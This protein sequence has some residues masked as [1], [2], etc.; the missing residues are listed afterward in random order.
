MATASTRRPTRAA[1]GR[2]CGTSTTV[3]RR[4]SRPRSSSASRRAAGATTAGALVEAWGAFDSERA[5]RLLDEVL[6][7]P[8]PEVVVS[9]VV[10]PALAE[11]RDRWAPD[12]LGTAR[13]HFASR[14][15]ETRLLALGERW[16]EAPGPLALV[17]CG[18]RESDTLGPIAFALALHRRGWR[19][20]YFGADAPLAGYSAAARALHADLV[21][22]S[23]TQPWAL[24]SADAELALLAR[25]LPLALIGAAADEATATA[26]GARALLGDPAAAA[27][28]A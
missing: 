16:H 5:H 7:D 22:I 11:A 14:Q 21:A 9:R 26:V 6:D 23:F 1:H 3:S 20:A 17:G 15:L 19:I 18:P 24:A 4:A 27:A 25:E 13:G 8:A 28:A 2:C 10:L 12:V